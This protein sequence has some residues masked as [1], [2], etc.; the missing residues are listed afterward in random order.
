[1]AR[2]CRGRAGRREGRDR[3]SGPERSTARRPPGDRSADRAADALRQGRDC[4]PCR[5]TCNP[6]TA[7]VCSGPMFRDVPLA[8][9]ALVRSRAVSAAVIVTLALGMAGA[10]VVFALVRGVLLR[11]LPVHEPDAVVVAWQTLPASGF[12]HDPFGAR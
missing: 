8:M 10:T 9:R 3:G 11:P 12:D 6:D 4:W 7:R 1:P 5:A 2:S